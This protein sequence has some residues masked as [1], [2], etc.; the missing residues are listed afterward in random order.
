M[1]FENRKYVASVKKLPFASSLA[2]YIQSVPIII[3]LAMIS[4]TG[5][6]FAVAIPQLDRKLTLNVGALPMLETWS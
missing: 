3:M 5:V 1:I 4:M 2:L 6:Q